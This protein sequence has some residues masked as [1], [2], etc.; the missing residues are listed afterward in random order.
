MLPST[1]RSRVVTFIRQPKTWA[2]SMYAM[3]L[4]LTQKALTVPRHPPGGGAGDREAY[5]KLSALREDGLLG[6]I[7]SYSSAERFE[8]A[9]GDKGRIGPVKGV[10]RKPFSLGVTARLSWRRFSSSISS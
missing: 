7:S 4:F 6:R 3:P 2:H 8:M 1:S 9:S 10:D 5:R